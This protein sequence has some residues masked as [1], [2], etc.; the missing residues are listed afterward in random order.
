VSREHL[1][2]LRCLLG[3]GWSLVEHEQGWLPCRAQGT[4]VNEV[5]DMKHEWLLS[6]RIALALTLDAHIP[7]DGIHR[8]GHPLLG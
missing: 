1:G 4:S 3:L 2:C 6:L 5:E 8:Q 7:G